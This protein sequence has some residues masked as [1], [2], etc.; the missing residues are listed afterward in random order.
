[1][2]PFSS[3]AILDRLAHSHPPYQEVVSFAFHH[4]SSI[5][6][7]RRQRRNP[8]PCFLFQDDFQAFQDRAI[9]KNGVFFDPNLDDSSVTTGGAYL[10]H[11]VSSLC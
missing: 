8:R 3:S 6:K 1:V 9:E 4:H 11:V 10:A 7:Q 2:R 5:T